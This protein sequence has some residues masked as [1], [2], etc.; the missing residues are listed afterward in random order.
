MNEIEKYLT[1]FLNEDRLHENYEEHI[2]KWNPRKEPGAKIKK[3]CDSVPTTH[4]FAEEIDNG[5]IS[6]FPY[7]EILFDKKAILSS[8]T[9]RSLDKGAPEESFQNLGEAQDYPFFVYSYLGSHDHYYSRLR[10]ENLPLPA[11][12]VFI[13]NA[14]DKEKFSN[15]TRVDLSSP[16]ANKSEKDKEF[17]TTKLARKYTAYKIT[18]DHVNDIINYCGDYSKV[19]IEQYK[20]DHSTWKTEFHYLYKVDISKIEAV[21]WPYMELRST[22]GRLDD[23][24]AINSIKEFKKFQPNIKVYPYKWSRVNPEERFMFSSNIIL[25]SI[26]ESGKYIDNIDFKRLFVR[27]FGM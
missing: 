22:A 26:F 23:P 4:T 12:G 19:C 14:V 10:G 6:Y 17:L 27:E 11:F 7:R 3:W 25:K 13:S 15:A 18:N 8:Y 24:R 16:E 5:K 20:K 9:R 1:D 21:I 2:S